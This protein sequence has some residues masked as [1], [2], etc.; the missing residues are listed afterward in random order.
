[1][2]FFDL[3]IL[4]I[5]ERDVLLS[6]ANGSCPHEVLETWRG[7]DRQQADAVVSDVIDGD[8]RISRNES[9][10]AGM[11][12]SD[13]VSQMHSG[14]SGLQKEEFICPGVSMCM[15]FSSRS[16]VCREK[17]QMRGPTIL[18]VNLQ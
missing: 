11:H 15:D 17:N 13:R 18:R 2:H 8:P 3:I 4:S 12:V 5:R 6:F 9:G 7:K 16:E 1:M 14:R 10:S